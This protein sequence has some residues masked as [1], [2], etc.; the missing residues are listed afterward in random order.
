MK[1]I[2]VAILT[3]VGLAVAAPSKAAVLAGYDFSGASRASTDTDLNTAASTFDGG[4]GFQT[5][6]VDNSTFD[7]THGNP[8]PAMA[9]DSTFTDGTTQAQA[10][11]AN[12]F[13]TFTISPVSGV[14]FS[15]TSLSFDYSNY[16]STT[17]FPTEN[18]FVRTSADGF[19]NNLAT[20]VTVASTTTGAFTNENISL[21][22]NSALQN[23]SGPLELRIYVFDSTSTVGRGALLDNI[24]LNGTTAM[25][26]EPSTWLLTAVGLAGLG[27]AR[28]LSRARSWFKL[29]RADR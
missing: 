17:T 24:M 11:A 20:G 1:T 14:S 28:R 3:A 7:L 10:V 21:T 13:Y 22:G 4:P 25:I 29:A 12:D 6:G 8:A 26:P 2:I 27:M 16:S 23:V 18:F 5:V 19:A 15:L 9:I